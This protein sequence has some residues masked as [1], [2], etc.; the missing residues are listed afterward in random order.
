MSTRQLTILV[1]VDTSTSWNAE[2]IRGIDEYAQA[3]PRWLLGVEAR[4]LQELSVPR[5][6]NGDGIIAR[7]TSKPLA[8]QLKRA[9]VPVV[10]VS[11]SKVPGYPFPQVTSD[12]MGI[13]KLAAQHLLTCGFRHFAYCGLP[14]QANY[15][16]GC[17][18][19]FIQE[20]SQHGHGVQIFMPRKPILPDW[21]AV[22]VP[23]L[24]AWIRS[25][26]RP[27]GVLAWGPEWGRKVTD[28]CRL[29]GI[30]VPDEVGVITTEDDELMCEISHPTLSAV[31]ERPR[32]MGYEAAALLDQMMAGQQP[33]KN[34]VLI[35]PQRVI[36]RHSTHLVAIE[37]PD[38]NAAA[39]FIR[40]RYIE[41]I[42][43][44]RLLKV[45][46]ISRRI[47]EQKFKLALGRSPAAEIRRVRLL[48][49]TELLATTDWPVWQVAK[50]SGF[51]H[52]E[53][54]NRVF[55]RELQL[56]PTR[57]RN[58]NKHTELRKQ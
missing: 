50:A 41:P 56:T 40:D 24:R 45:V 31:D 10:N 13:G 47:L 36:T 44:R 3:Q 49:A 23:N 12:E 9:G 46:A 27:T 48:R 32:L 38:V 2:V 7:V 4:G 30:R 58:Q 6:W 57:Y 28:A 42:D 29:E 35:P 55:Q 37:D 21:Q 16:D 20:L 14:N 54:M 19:A 33:P 39:R 51:A 17:G 26:K 34:P 11:W 25:L 5:H 1:L 18:P 8:R 43:V 22:S 52:V 53:G 15:T